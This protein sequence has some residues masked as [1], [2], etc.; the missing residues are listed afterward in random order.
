MGVRQ[1]AR[2]VKVI[3]ESGD[4]SQSIFILIVY[5]IVINKN[6][7]IR[8]IIITQLMHQGLNRV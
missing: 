7:G 6:S 3:T 2:C 5:L 8:N 4:A 1:S